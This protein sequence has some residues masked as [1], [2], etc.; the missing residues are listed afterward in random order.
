M[1]GVPPIMMPLYYLGA[2]TTA[3]SG[4]SLVLSFIQIARRKTFSAHKS[5]VMW[6]SIVLA[7]AGGVFSFVVFRWTARVPSSNPY[8]DA[9]WNLRQPGYLDYP[10][11]ALLLLLLIPRLRRPWPSIFIVL[12]A[13]MCNLHELFVPSHL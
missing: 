12:A 13:N 3:L 4:L 10:W 11:P 1:T 8:E 2:F 9:A 7:L 6:V 5:P